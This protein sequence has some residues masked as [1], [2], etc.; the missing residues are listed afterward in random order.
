MGASVVSIF[1]FFVLPISIL[2]KRK[3][4]SFIDIKKIYLF[5][6]IF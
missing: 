4:K 5:L 3:G 1:R 2:K 6:R